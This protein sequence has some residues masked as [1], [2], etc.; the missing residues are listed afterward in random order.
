LKK[1][2]PVRFDFGFISLKLNQTE[3]NPNRKTPEKTEPNREKPS[4]TGKTEPNRF[5]SQNN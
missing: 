2:N 5:F 3:P 4:Q 1:T